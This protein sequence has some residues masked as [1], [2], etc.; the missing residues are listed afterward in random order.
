MHPY[1]IH[2]LYPQM[3]IEKK[4][5]GKNKPAYIDAPKHALIHSVTC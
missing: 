2:T 5:L 4:A 1:E 3:D